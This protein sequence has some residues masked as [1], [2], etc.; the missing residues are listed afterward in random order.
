M[1]V[2]LGMG[3]AIAAAAVWAMAP[4]LYRRGIEKVSYT[5]LGAVRC[6]GYVLSATAY[7][8]AAK[9]TAA[10]IPPET[11]TL[12]FLWA[13]SVAWLVVGDLCYF[14]ALHKLGV[15]VGV[16]ATSSFPVVAVVM[17]HFVIKEPMGANII[18]SVLLTLEGLFLLNR[19]DGGSSD[20]PRELTGGL[21]L[22]GATM[23]CWSLGVVS[24][25]ILIGRMDIPTL[26][27]WRSIGVTVG[28]I[29]AF[30]IKN[31]GEV[32]SLRSL[33]GRDLLE[34]SIAGAMGLTIG[35]LL[36]S[37]SLNYISVALATCLACARPFLAALFAMAVL[38]ERLTR[39]VA[40]G[41]TLVVAG[42][43]VMSL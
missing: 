42:V 11:H 30:L 39:K 3:L 4:V 34:M 17:S 25:K 2:L 16:P 20:S 22:A 35:N 38:R 6:I 15:S 41:I 18:I 27:L 40:L 13:S 19:K 5:A 14:G 33:K 36:F 26:E 23:F 31:P 1:R 12:A 37:Y 7:A 24:N 8:L 32:K 43:T 28:S 9:G 10:F 21:I 29:A